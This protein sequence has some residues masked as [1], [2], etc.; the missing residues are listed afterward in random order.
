MQAKNVLKLEVKQLV[1]VGGVGGGRGRGWVVVGG[2]ALLLL[3]AADESL[4][5]VFI[6][7]ILGGKDKWMMR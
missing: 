5:D 3:G 4:L 2:L 1:R 7:Q 6:D